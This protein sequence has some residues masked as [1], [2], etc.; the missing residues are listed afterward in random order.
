[1]LSPGKA[2]STLSGSIFFFSLVG[3]ISSRICSFILPDSRQGGS[4]W[5]A[6]LEMS[7][8]GPGAGPPLHSPEWSVT[9]SLATAIKNCLQVILLCA[10]RLQ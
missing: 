7:Q 4:L 2:D 6:L 1:M 10:L 3:I 5:G 9:Y 8:E